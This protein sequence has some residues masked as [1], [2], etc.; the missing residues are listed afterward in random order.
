MTAGSRAASIEEAA[1]FLHK[2]S[3]SNILVMVYNKICMGAWERGLSE[4]RGG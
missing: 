2:K 3:L 4:R 1:L